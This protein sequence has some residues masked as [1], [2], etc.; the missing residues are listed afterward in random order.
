M[1][2]NF[3]KMNFEKIALLQFTLPLLITKRVFIFQNIFH[4]HICGLEVVIHTPRK[5]K[6]DHNKSSLKLDVNVSS[7]KII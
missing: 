5:I 7:D 1:K 4:D 3:Y 6:N 2:E